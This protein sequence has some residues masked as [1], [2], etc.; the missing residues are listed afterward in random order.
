MSRRA[1]PLPP[2]LGAA[3]TYDA[4][5]ERGLTPRRL[6]HR[7]LV[8]PT[9]GLRLTDETR[10]LRERAA[11]YLLL[12]PAGRVAFSHATAAALLDLPAPRDERLHVTL[13]RGVFVRRRGVVMHHGLDSREIRRTGDLPVTS[14]LTTWLDLAA[15]LSID[16]L[17]ILGDAIAN[18]AP[19]LLP[20]FARIVDSSAGRRGIRTAR[21]AAAL[22]QPGVL[23]PQETL[24]RLRFRKAGFPAPALNVD[25]HDA[26]GFRLGMGD[27]VWREQ[28]VVAEYD[29]DYHFTVDQRRLDQARRRAMRAADWAVIEL[30]GADNRNPEPAMR[31]L[32]RALRLPGS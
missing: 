18:R 8:I 4:A 6:R 20:G 14:A 29:G 3:F 26:H 24:W 21:A 7:G 13:P 10:A 22:I 12:L 30:N 28:R 5:R 11:A 19:E 25:V 23:S 32:A 1:T 27:F 31:A 16:D 15:E 17:V 9:R 2:E